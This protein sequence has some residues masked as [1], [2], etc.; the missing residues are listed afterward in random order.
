MFYK[1][2]LQLKTPKIKTVVFDDFTGGMNRNAKREIPSKYASRCFNFK[3]GYG[4]LKQNMGF[5]KLPVDEVVKSAECF[6]IDG[7]NFAAYVNEENAVKVFAADRPEEARQ[8][9]SAQGDTKLFGFKSGQN[10][11]LLISDQS[12]VYVYDGDGVSK[13]DG[14]P[15]LDKAVIYYE[16]IFGIAQD[17]RLYFSAVLNPSNWDEGYYDGGYIEFDDNFGKALDAVSFDG[18]LFVSGGDKIAEVSA[19]SAQGEFFVSKIYALH[20]DIIKNTVAV[21]GGK[22]VFLTSDGIYAFDGNS[23]KKLAS[24]L[25][26]HFEINGSECACYFNAKYYLACKLDFFDKRRICC[27]RKSFCN[28]TLVEISVADGSVNICRG[29]DIRSLS[30]FNGLLAVTDGKLAFLDDS[31]SCFGQPLPKV[32]ESMTGDFGIDGRKNIKS[33]SL[34]TATDLTVKIS[35][36][37]VTSIFLIDGKRKFQRIKTGVSGIYFKI[38]LECN[39]AKPQIIRPSLEV[40]YTKGG[41]YY[42]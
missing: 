37:G 15:P 26:Y 8:I 1:K 32:W 18:K 3:G 27:E 36:D 21:C 22:I 31:G 23:A 7:K 9:F 13:I 41:G 12:G 11:C 16:R 14:V 40:A 20:G 19:T 10:A 6:N 24:E 4:S 42:D 33:I 34:Y 39:S 29:I 28:N 38:A 2:Q 30:K 35:A 25:D 5:S 17:G